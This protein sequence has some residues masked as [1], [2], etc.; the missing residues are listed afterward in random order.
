MTARNGG[1]FRPP[2]KQ[3]FRLI[4][5]VM[6]ARVNSDREIRKTGK[7]SRPTADRRLKTA[8]RFSNA[9]ARAHVL[10]DRHR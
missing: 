2:A 5:P 6:H 3:G 7:T 8:G 10:T 4:A 9:R 1:S